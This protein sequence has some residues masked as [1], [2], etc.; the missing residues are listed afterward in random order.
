MLINDNYLK[1]AFTIICLLGLSSCSISID[2]TKWVG[3]GKHDDTEL[4]LKNNEGFVVL[5]YPQNE[6]DTFKITYKQEGNTVII[7]RH[8]SIV[9]VDQSGILKGDTLDFGKGFVLVK[10]K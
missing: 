1:V 9:S 2:N 5:H 8:D 10:I 7:S 3:I 4:I 6:T